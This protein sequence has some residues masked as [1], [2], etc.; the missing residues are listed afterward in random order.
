MDK[1]RKVEEVGFKT[2]ENVKDWIYPGQVEKMEAKKVEAIGSVWMNS[3]NLGKMELKKVESE[4][5][6]ETWT[7]KGS[8]K[9]WKCVQERINSWSLG[10]FHRKVLG[11]SIKMTSP[12]KKVSSLFNNIYKSFIY[13]TTWKY[14]VTRYYFKKV[15]F[16][17][18]HEYM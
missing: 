11:Q 9:N 16:N 10:C 7:S 15:Y 18:F 2:D 17:Y 12:K 3:G 6:L 13:K 5:V 4:K 14:Y 8:S 1:P